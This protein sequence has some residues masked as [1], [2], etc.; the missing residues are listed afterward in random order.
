MRIEKN[1]YSEI[2][3]LMPILCVDLIIENEHGLMLQIKRINEPLA[4]EWWTIGGRVMKMETPREAAR[5]LAREEVGL[6][7]KEL[8][9][10]GT[11]AE[12]FPKSVA[13]ADG[14]H[15]ISI[16]YKCKAASDKVSLDSQSSDFRW[17]V[18]LPPRFIANLEL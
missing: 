17:S 5:R 4:G 7:I 10:A 15:T 6:R 14:I 9:L 8:E 12:Y 1:K 3:Q 13:C 16:V 11:Y 2:C 18:G